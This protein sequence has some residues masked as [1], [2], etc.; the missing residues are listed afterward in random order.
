M[1][2]PTASNGQPH[3]RVGGRS[4]VPG[5]TRG[6]P[7]FDHRRIMPG[8]AA[9][10]AL[11]HRPAGRD[12]LVSPLRPLTARNI[13]VHVRRDGGHDPSAYPTLTSRGVVLPWSNPFLHQSFIQPGRKT[14]R[15][16]SPTVRARN[17]EV[18]EGVTNSL[19]LHSSL[20]SIVVPGPKSRPSCRSTSG[21]PAPRRR[22]SRSPDGP[23]LRRA[24]GSV[25]CS[26]AG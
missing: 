13:L 1:S 2:R 3:C 23:R 11:A 14:C 4:R 9:L 25:P 17:R 10:A 8:F 24:S 26:F 20:L 16:T 5:S 22:G 18:V 15:A 6:L 7:R 21:F 19:R 12:V